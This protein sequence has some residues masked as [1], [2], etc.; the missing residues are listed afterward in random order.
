MEN[1]KATLTRTESFILILRTF[2]GHTRCYF[3]DSKQILMCTIYTV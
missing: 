1:E 3:S 2:D